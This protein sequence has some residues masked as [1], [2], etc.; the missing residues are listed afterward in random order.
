MRCRLI[1]PDKKLPRGKIRNTKAIE[2]PLGRKDLFAKILNTYEKTLNAEDGLK[3]TLTE[4][5][6]LLQVER[7]L[8]PE[9]VREIIV[10]WVESADASE[11]K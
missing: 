4:Y 9:L 11:D 10:T 6:K 7:D 5:L 3:P 2:T 8:E 1:M